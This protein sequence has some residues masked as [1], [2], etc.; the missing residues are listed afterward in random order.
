MYKNFKSGEISLDIEKKR[1]GP[2]EEF[3]VTNS[4]Q[5]NSFEFE[6]SRETHFF[7]KERRTV[8][9]IK[10]IF[11][12]LQQ[13]GNY[14]L[15]KK[16]NKEQ[17]NIPENNKNIMNNYYKTKYKDLVRERLYETG[18]RRKMKAVARD[19][20]KEKG[21]DNITEESLVEEMTPTGRALVPDSVKR[22]LLHLVLK[23][24]DPDSP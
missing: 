21:I 10:W 2:P 1:P 12:I 11:C 4:A 6:V 7:T 22:E 19:I 8:N 5:K 14:F 15:L 13:E 24:L 9:E 16:A 23:R 20:I 18:W 17:Q 3:R